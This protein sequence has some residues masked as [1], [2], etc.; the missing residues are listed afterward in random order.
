MP[1]RKLTQAAFLAITD[2]RRRWRELR[3]AQGLCSA[4]GKEAHVADGY[5]GLRC[6][7]K[8]RDRMRARRGSTDPKPRRSKYARLYALLDRA[9]TQPS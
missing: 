1:S 4:C 3:H 6:L 2:R 5:L 9:E 7:R 8:H